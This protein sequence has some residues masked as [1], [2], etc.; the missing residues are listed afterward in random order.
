MCLDQREEILSNVYLGS[1]VSKGTEKNLGNQ[2][3]S[4]FKKGRIRPRV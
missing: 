1:M 4:G 2:V 3:S